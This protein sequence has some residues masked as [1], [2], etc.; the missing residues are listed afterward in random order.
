MIPVVGATVVV[1]GTTMIPD[2][3]TDNSNLID[4]MPA[5]LKSQFSQIPR[6][7]F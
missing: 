5:L 6:K 4:H 7:G 3:V 2:P 1:P